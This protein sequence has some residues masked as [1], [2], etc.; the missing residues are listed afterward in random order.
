MRTQTAG[1]NC[2]VPASSTNRAPIAQIHTLQTA[3]VTQKSSL[4]TTS[5]N[6]NASLSEIKLIKVVNRNSPRANM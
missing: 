4:K 1:T 5:T 6:N 2:L 3:Q